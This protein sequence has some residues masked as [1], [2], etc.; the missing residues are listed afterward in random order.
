MLYT[1]IKDMNI[2]MMNRHI[3]YFYSG[4]VYI[5]A[6]LTFVKAALPISSHYHVVYCIKI[7]CDAYKNM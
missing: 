7:H 5:A 2:A 1:L 4:Q 6:L 3:Q